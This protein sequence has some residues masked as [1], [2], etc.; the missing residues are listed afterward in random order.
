M[1][2]S[3]ARIS[4]SSSPSSG[5]SQQGSFGNKSAP[6]S[7]AARRRSAEAAIIAGFSGSLGK[8][9]ADVFRRM[10]SFKFEVFGKVQGTTFR[11]HTQQRGTE[12][13]LVGFVKNNPS[14]TVEGEVQ[15]GDQEKLAEMERWLRTTGSP[16]SKIERLDIRDRRTIDGLTYSGFEIVGVWRA[17]RRTS[18]PG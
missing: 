10:Y 12:L 1:S 8:Q 3:G 5:K 7:I 13:G 14:G 11:K 18:L 15:G 2:F 4:G 6:M 9:N 17:G 16:Q